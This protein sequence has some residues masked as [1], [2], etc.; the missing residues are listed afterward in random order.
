MQ[1]L[2]QI[3]MPALISISLVIMG[4]LM[5]EPA[6][7][8]LLVDQRK[9][10]AKNM[11]TSTYNLIEGLNQKVIKGEITL[12]QAQSFVIE[13]I[14]LKRY[15]E[16]NTNYLWLQDCK[17]TLIYHPVLDTTLIVNAAVLA[18]IDTVALHVA[19][20]AREN[21]EGFFSYTWY[22]L[23]GQ[24]TISS[25]KEAYIKIYP[26][27]NWIIGTGFMIQDI[28]SDL[29]NLTKDVLGSLAIFLGC[30]L[31]VLAFT[32]FRNY[33]NLQR[34]KVADEQL[35]KREEGFR[36]FV[37]HLESGLLIF[38][39]DVPVYANANF[40]NIFDGFDKEV[41]EFELEY[42][43]P[44]WEKP[45]VR[46]LL[47]Q[48]DV[49][50]TQIETWVKTKNGLDKYVC[51][52]LSQD[53]DLGRPYKYFLVKDITE[54]HQ[55][56]ATM[57][58]LSQ[59]LAQSSDSV[60]ITDL[61]GN[62]EYVNPGFEKSTGYSFEEVKGKN[63][64]IMKSNK[65]RPVVYKDLWETVSNGNIWQ[66]EL[67]N[68]KKDGT[69][70]WEDTTIFP[71]KNKQNEIIKYSSIKRDITHTKAFEKQLMDA[72]EKAEENERLK[73]AFLN[74]ISHEVRTPLNAVYGF[75]QLLKTSIEDKNAIYYLDLVEHNC[76]I[77]LKLFDDI[78][79]YSHIES[80][81]IQL[82][83]EDIKLKKLLDDIIADFYNQIRTS[84]KPQVKI[85]LESPPE[86]KEMVIFTDVKRL[87]QIFEKIL[88]NAL[89]YTMEGSIR[90]SYDVDYEY[91]TFH[92]TDSGV[93]IS[94]E[95]KQR[96][97]ESF[98]HGENLEV[99]LHKGVGLGLNIARQ[100]VKILG[101]SLTFASSVGKGST[102]SFSLPTVDL[103]NYTLN[104]EEVM[105]Y[106]NMIRGKKILIAEDNDENFKYLENIFSPSNSL[107]RAKT[108][109]EAVRI[110][111]SLTVHPDVILMDILMPEMDGV[112]ASRLIRRIRPS[113]PIIA[114][115]AVETNIGKNELYI[116]DAIIGKP[117]KFHALFEKLHQ[118][119]SE[120]YT[121]NY[122]RT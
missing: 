92:I 59:N 99:S 33:R 103:K 114:I 110:I 82:N 20:V 106:Q 93:G 3:G 109:S 47:I 94:Q 119:T 9:Q 86:F 76:E 21:Q 108:G 53:C 81:A 27:W 64:R 15:G 72:K 75:T 101:G 48:C 5:V 120:Y 118:V 1:L 50:D 115:T 111:E 10:A 13:I 49:S 67:L 91:L 16:N 8:R 55:V 24:S 44:E 35:K 12:K 80:G 65:M 57:N 89:K 51:I 56:A 79:D 11:V 39:N 45:R 17:G 36:R 66:G 70:F 43:L 83:K 69:L 34:I 2:G 62:I 7:K 88:G 4:Y 63:P 32:L 73:S 30:M 28:K 100:L 14:L 97:W 19:K 84:D 74:N 107:I 52:N 38:E 6:T 87:R 95:E 122:L 78:I 37:E 102:F 117:I 71:I 113:I 121:T 41:H 31:T 26:A 68:V 18:N 22:P 23:S 90:I 85:V 77:L 25:T 29:Q 60:V 104:G 40:R 112:S 98:T 116:F 42:F 96:I 46:Q 61:N 54:Q 105:M 58:M